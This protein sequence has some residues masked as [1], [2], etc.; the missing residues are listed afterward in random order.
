M[1]DYKELIEAARFYKP[2]FGAS[3][4]GIVYNDLVDAIEQLVKARGILRDALDAAHEDERKA[5]AKAAKCELAVMRLTEELADMK[6]ERGVQ[7]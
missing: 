1:N 5:E 2:V 7:E 4:V 6:L 3:P